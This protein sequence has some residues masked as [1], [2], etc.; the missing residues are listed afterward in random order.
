MRRRSELIIY[1]F[2]PAPVKRIEPDPIIKAA[3]EFA[4][5]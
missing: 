3:A 5:D 1:P 2:A 4:K